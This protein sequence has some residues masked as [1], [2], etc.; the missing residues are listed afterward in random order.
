MRRR[1]LLSALLTIGSVAG[2]SAGCSSPHHG[3]R[4]RTTGVEQPVHVIA[5]DGSVPSILRPRGNAPARPCRA[6]ELRVVGAGFVFSPGVA[7]GTGSV[8]LRNA[9]RVACRLTGRP[10]VRLVGA[11]KQP[12]QRQLNLSAQPAAFPQ[13]LPPESTLL[14]LPP[15]GTATLSIDWRN[16][17]VPGAGQTP[18]AVVPPQ[19]VRVTLP[20]GLGS[21]DVAYNAV[22]ACDSP[23]Q[24]S[25]VGV[26]PFQP[27][28]LHA[29][30]WTTAALRATIAPLPG[31][32]IR[33]AGRRGQVARFAIR[34]ENA[35]RQVVRFDRCPLLVETLEPAGA[36]E[37]HQLNCRDATP[38]APGS[39]LAFEMRIRVPPNAPLG[40][41]GLFWEL[42]PT[43]A[44]GPQV[45]S[46]LVVSG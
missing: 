26:R 18:K 20:G 39:W 13:V 44:E 10:L 23:G 19:A 42:D 27:A 37:V 3:G 32:P 12:P 40:N 4:P 29:P 2:L 28:P 7:G 35:S 16:W 25:T 15:A 30:A 1:R 9:G 8:T 21:L 6:A 31:A 17:C 46:G 22:P 45:V 36:P 43:G 34:L 41:N 38:I 24:P 33:L 11:P 14:A 5:W